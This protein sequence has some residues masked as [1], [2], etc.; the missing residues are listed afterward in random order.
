MIAPNLH[1]LCV[2]FLG[3]SDSKKLWGNFIIDLF[4]LIYILWDGLTTTKQA[5]FNF[6]NSDYASSFL[7]V[8]GILR[9]IMSSTTFCHALHSLGSVCSVYVHQKFAKAFI[10]P[11][12]WSLASY[13]LLSEHSRYHSLW[14]N[15]K[16]M[17][18]SH[19]NHVAKLNYTYYQKYFC[20]KIAVTV[21]CFTQATPA[22]LKQNSL[23]KVSADVLLLTSQLHDDS[24]FF[25][26]FYQSLCLDSYQILKAK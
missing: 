3:L 6:T 7:K 24:V 22:S 11:S 23:A 9:E 13:L 25:V 15:I 8:V 2:L 4:V 19:Q 20:S 1:Q 14:L 10:Q 5:Y 17:V 26:L 18:S 16:R 21:R 12:L